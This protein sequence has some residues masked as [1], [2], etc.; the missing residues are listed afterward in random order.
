MQTK[1][2]T[3]ILLLLS[4]FLF[5][6]SGNAQ[7]I[8]L[9]NDGTSIKAKV[10]DITTSEVKYKR[11]DYKDGPTVTISI[12]EI[13]TIKYPNGQIETFN[14]N[15]NS[16]NTSA[17]TQKEPEKIKDGIVK[18]KYPSGEL[19]CETPFVNG[20]VNGIQKL[21]YKNGSL[22]S[23]TPF[24]DG[25]ANGLSIVYYKNGKKM[26]EIP[27]VNGNI[28]GTLKQ[29]YIKRDI[30]ILECSFIDNKA[31][32]DKNTKHCRGGL[33][34]MVFPPNCNGI[35][36]GIVKM[37]YKQMGMKLLVEMPYS[38]NVA[39]GREKIFNKKGEYLQY[40]DYVDGE[41]LKNNNDNILGAVVQ[42]VQQAVSYN[43]M[44]T[45]T[46]TQTVNEYT[47]VMVNNYTKN[48][49]DAV[50]ANSSII[51]S[52]NSSS[53][54]STTGNTSIT[55]AYNKSSANLNELQKS[56][57]AKKNATT[58]NNKQFPSVSLAGNAGSTV[59]NGTTSTGANGQNANA[60][61]QQ[62]IQDL[63]TEEEK[64]H[65]SLEDNWYLDNPNPQK[66]AMLACDDHCPKYYCRAHHKQ[67]SN[68]C[69]CLSKY[70]NANKA[71]TANYELKKAKC[72]AAY[73]RAMQR[74]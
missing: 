39:N 9:K 6:I 20:K 19:L 70:N 30:C 27:W 23:E 31:L 3:L 56:N 10:L 4:V 5:E 43:N 42:G 59:Q 74:Q 26:F 66:Y 11:F 55:D 16:A 44:M 17:T 53:T 68:A 15:T 65:K 21:Y 38:N 2:L 25:L 33:K 61:Y 34:E 52:N 29:F 36:N 46:N 22:T 35:I 62:C 71:I 8:I 14:K 72:E 32:I 12:S 51:S 69:D 18:T 67:C 47:Q 64:E 1:S 63:N 40:G 58:T 54:S 37:T 7:D 41:E 49:E 24:V 50:R 60:I 45:N 73:N 13:S 48:S 57:E 28:N